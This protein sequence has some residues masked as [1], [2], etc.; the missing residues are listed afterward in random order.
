MREEWVTTGDARYAISQGFANGSRV[1]TAAA[2]I[3]FFVF[4]A[5]V[6]EGT[7]AIKAI[8]LG[9]AVG[10]AI[11]AF[12][13]RMT[14][15][16]AIMTILGTSAWW[17]PRW[18]GAFLPNVD[19]EGE[20]LR[21]HRTAIDWTASQDGAVISA[22]YLIAGAGDHRVGP[23]TATIAA[24]SFVVVAG[25]ITERRILAATLAGRLDPVAGRVQV[26]G[27]PL[28][29]ESSRVA[30]LVALA[31]IGALEQSEAGVRVGALLRERLETTQ[32][33]HRMWKTRRRAQGWIDR[34]N[35]AIRVVS[36]NTIVTIDGAR[37][38]S[39]LPQLERAIT[40]AALALIEGTPVVMLDQT[41]SFASEEDEAAFVRSLALLAATTTTIFFGTSVP[42]RA[43]A[44]D[45]WVEPRTVTIVDLYS[46]AVTSVLTKGGLR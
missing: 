26:A 18:L 22:D 21:Q 6:P 43:I 24:G 14:L 41:D 5:F 46:G 15:V 31:D 25:P 37:T 35:A 10:I 9:L 42:A 28:P 19:V 36:P 3:M 23:V 44:V 20:E 29:S 17:M 8:A 27:H 40:L 32:P 2:L 11:D 30:A 38:L 4:F 1:V 39:E 13:I 45:A 16:P 12:L 34:I 33:W 7:G